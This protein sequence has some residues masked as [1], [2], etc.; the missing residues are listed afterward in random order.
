MA[1]AFGRPLNFTV[2]R[3][4]ELAVKWFVRCMRRYAQFS[5]RASRPE[6]WWFYAVVVAVGLPLHFLAP[7]LSV[8]G[9][10]LRAVWSFGVTLPHLAVMSRRLHDSG[11][12]FWWGGAFFLAIAFLAA[13]GLAVRGRPPISNP[14]PAFI[15]GIYMLGWFALAFRLLYLLCK[16]GDAGSNRYGEPAPEVPN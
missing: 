7:H 6:Y 8:V 12:S 1:D 13:V 9:L 3:P 14:L 11:H 4:M 16:Q 10:A 5:G 2:R 15:F